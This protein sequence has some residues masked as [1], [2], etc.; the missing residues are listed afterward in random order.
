MTDQ[1][2]PRNVTLVKLG[3]RIKDAA[4][5]LDHIMSSFQR[6]TNNIHVTHCKE[7]GMEAFINLM[8]G[9]GQETITGDAVFKHCQPPTKPAARPLTYE[10]VR[11]WTWQQQQNVYS[12]HIRNYNGAPRRFKVTRYQTWKRDPNRLFFV[13]SGGPNNSG[14]QRFEITNIDQLAG[15]SLDDPDDYKYPN[16]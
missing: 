3:M 7:C 4:G 9:Q 6:I 16:T 12:L 15:W 11:S 1:K 10:Q 13:L 14:H 5:R 8:P 2:A